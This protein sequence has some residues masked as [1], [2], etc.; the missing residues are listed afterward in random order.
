MLLNATV[1]YDNIVQKGYK[2][3]AGFHVTVTTQFNKSVA[4]FIV[5]RNVKFGCSEC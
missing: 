5:R 4:Y 3:Y 1:I 2:S